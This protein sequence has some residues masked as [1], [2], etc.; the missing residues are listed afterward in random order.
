MKPVKT[1]IIGSG[2]ISHVY[3]RNL[4]NLLSIID[5]AALGGRNMETVRRQAETYGVGQVMTM[6]EIAADPSIELV[7]NL[8]PADAHYEIVKN[9]LLAGK[10]VYTEK[11]LCT[12]LEQGRE[13]VNLAHEKGLYLGVAPDTILGAGMQTARRALEQGQIGNVTS[14]LVAINRD[15]CLN[16][17]TYRF[18]QKSGGNLPEDV[19]VYY[20]AALLS[21][22]G[23]AEQVFAFGTSAP[24]HQKELLYRDDNPDSW[25]VPGLN[26]LSAAV[27]FRS[28]ATASILF[29]GNTVNLPQHTFTIYG[30]EGILQVGD[31]NCFDGP[32]TLLLP[33]N[34]PCVLPFSHGF[35]G[36]PTLPDPTPYEY[37]YG[38]RGIGVAEMAWSI[39]RG[40]P[41]RLSGELGLAA[42]EI[43]KG[44]ETSALEGHPVRLETSFVCPGLKPGFYSTAGG[45]RGDAERSLMD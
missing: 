6:E 18:L 24:V 11:P 2:M 32:A 23:P 13:L 17:E 25:Q 33:E 8:T 30:T 1:A 14:C 39:R 35:N 42:L 40:R 12:D 4:K 7:V 37:V 26:L 3:I 19:G 45:G 41:H 31:P 29:D 43:L 5:L 28:G 10:H 36:K 34:E 9:M 38:H 22:L 44:F 20:I 27:K 21:L 16:S 15:Q